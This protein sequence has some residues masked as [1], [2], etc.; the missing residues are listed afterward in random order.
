MFQTDTDTDKANPVRPPVID[1][2]LADY[3]DTG[4]WW[5]GLAM[6][7]DGTN[8][9]ALMRDMYDADVGVIFFDKDTIGDGDEYLIRQYEDLGIIALSK[10]HPSPPPGRVICSVRDTEDG[11]VALHVP[12]DI[13]RLSQQGLLDLPGGTHLAQIVGWLIDLGISGPPEG[14]DG[15]EIEETL[16]EHGLAYVAPYDPEAHG[17]VEDTEPGD[18]I[19]VLTDFARSAWNLHLA[20]QRSGTSFCIGI[21]ALEALKFVYTNHRGE[22]ALRRVVPLGAPWYGATR[23]HPTPQHFLTA[24]D[25][26]KGVTRDFAWHDIQ[27]VTNPQMTHPITKIAERQKRVAAERAKVFGPLDGRD[28]GNAVMRVVEEA[29]ETA[30][31]LGLDRADVLVLVAHVYG[32]PAGDP[33][34]E[35]GQTR[36]ATMGLAA[37]LHVDAEGLERIAAANFLNADIDALRAKAAAKRK[38]GVEDPRTPIAKDARDG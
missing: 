1:D 32:K 17:D 18:K 20:R 10:W 12:A 37:A 30:Q 24:R 36:L 31:A 11:P 29:V 35:L 33:A 26:D 25:L 21:R 28:I 9:A 4:R 34:N 8:L 14:I 5:R 38:A 3:G 13:P 7:P 6:L 27:P 2:T 23:H 15:R 22:T 16:C 19:L